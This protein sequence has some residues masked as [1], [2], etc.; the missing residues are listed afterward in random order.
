[1]TPVAERKKIILWIK[2][3]SAS[4][5]RLNK[6]CDGAGIS[7]RT[8]RRWQDDEGEV[9]GDQRP[10]A[11]RPTP[12]NK[13]T[14]TEQEQIIDVCNQP[15]YASLPPGQIVPRLLDLGVYLASESTFYRVLNENEMSNRRGRTA[16]PR[17]AAKPSTYEASAPNQVYCWDI[18]YL[19]MMVRGRF[20][21]LYLFEDLFDRM[22]VGAEVYEVECGTLATELLQRILINEKH[23]GQLLVLH[24][25]NGAPMKSQTLRV[26]LDELGITSSY[27]RPRVSDD[28]PYV[29][30]LF[31]T[32]KYCPQWPTSGFASLEEARSW[33][34]EFV[35]WY[36]YEHKH[37][38]LGFVTPYERRSGQDGS[39]LAHRKEVLTRAKTQHPERWGS[40]EIR[41]CE[42]VGSVWLNPEKDD[43][44]A[45]A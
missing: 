6:A 33:V 17:K 38:K 12:S 14:P 15:S 20:L 23:T 45:V 16:K 11:E 40:R 18:T 39:I 3:A 43:V 35:Q 31:R 29:E 8:Y 7:L 5:A 2:E 34:Q 19:P 26:K 27:S 44:K 1:M 9:L 36:N 13:L 41:N 10:E 32:L 22:I 37:S 42:P 30:S 24:S 28:N 4:G 25:D 21:Y